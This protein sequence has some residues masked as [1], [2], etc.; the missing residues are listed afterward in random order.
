MVSAGCRAY[1]DGSKPGHGLVYNCTD[2]IVEWDPRKAGLNVRKHGVH[3]ADAAAVLE[4]ERALTARDPSSL[5][6]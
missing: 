2:M 3:F 5:E 1:V 4:D 6:E